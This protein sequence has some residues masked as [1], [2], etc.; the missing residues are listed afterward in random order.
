M[1][2]AVNSLAEFAASVPSR[3][4]FRTPAAVG[5]MRAMAHNE[6]TLCLWVLWLRGQ[7][8]RKTKRKLKAGSIRSRVSLLVGLLSHR[9]GFRLVQD[10]IRLKALIKKLTAADPMAAVRRKRRGIRR[11]HLRRVWQRAPAV[12][13]TSVVARAEWAAATVAWHVLARGGEMALVQRSDLRFKRDG[14]KCVEPSADPSNDEAGAGLLDG[15]PADPN[16]RICAPNPLRE[17]SPILI[18][19]RDTRHS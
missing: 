3:T 10:P 19:A 11:R 16:C 7:V 13:R 2:T 12:R 9:Y 18:P 17:G 1:Q 5:D 8:S 14:L 6:W 4:L 15:C